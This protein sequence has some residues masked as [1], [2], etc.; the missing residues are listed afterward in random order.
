[1]FLYE[2]ADGETLERLGEV[3]QPSIADLFVAKVHG[4]ELRAAA[5]GG[6]A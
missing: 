5:A 1:V 6:A 2:D 3:R 4:A